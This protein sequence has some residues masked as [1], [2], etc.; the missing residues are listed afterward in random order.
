MRVSLIDVSLYRVLKS[1]GLGATG[2]FEHLSSSAQSQD[3]DVAFDLHITTS[4]SIV[5][6]GLG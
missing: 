4:Y 5:T 1:L 2:D 6:I 3:A